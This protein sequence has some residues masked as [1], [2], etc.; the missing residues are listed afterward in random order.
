M[1]KRNEKS[2]LTQIFSYSK[3]VSQRQLDESDIL[4]KPTYS[5]IIFSLLNIATNELFDELYCAIEDKIRS[6]SKKRINHNKFQEFIDNNIDLI[7]S[8]NEF[9]YF[10]LE[11]DENP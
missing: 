4:K 9:E 7:S 10:S 8:K 1:F 5:Y 6:S 2:K 3:S 11:D